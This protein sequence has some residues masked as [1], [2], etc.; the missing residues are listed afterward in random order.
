[1]V[2]EILAVSLQEFHISGGF[3]RSRVEL[4]HTM[5]RFTTDSPHINRNGAPT[6][7]KQVEAW[8]AEHPGGSVSKCAKELGISR[9]TARKWMPESIKAERLQA[10]SERLKEQLP[11]TKQQQIVDVLKQ[12]GKVRQILNILK[13]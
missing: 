8:Y 6:Q 7:Q 10:E 5:A 12:P 2:K 9:P 3:C 13:D 11:P 1:M 4:C